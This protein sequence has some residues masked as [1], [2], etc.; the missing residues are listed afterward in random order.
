[1]M[2]AILRGAVDIDVFLS[3]LMDIPKAFENAGR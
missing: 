1:M 2:M 3:E